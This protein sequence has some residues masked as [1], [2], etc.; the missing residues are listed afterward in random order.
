MII[1]LSVCFICKNQ[2]LAQ[3]CPQVLGI[4]Y[5]HLCTNCVG[6]IMIKRID[7]KNFD[8]DRDYLIQLQLLINKIKERLNG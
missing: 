5:N 3:A 6:C 1:K 4:C 7:R 2:A 8:N